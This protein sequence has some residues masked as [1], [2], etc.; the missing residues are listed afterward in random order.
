[1]IIPDV[2]VLV[3]AHQR[4]SRHFRQFSKLL[5]DV[6][7]GPSVV[8]IP[9][10]VVAGFARVV[11]NP[12]LNRSSQP[13]SHALIACRIL[14]EHHNTVR[15]S[16]SPRAWHIFED[17]STRANIRG[18]HLSDAYLAAVTIDAGAELLTADRGFKR[19]AGLRVT[20]VP[21]S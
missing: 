3:Y 8:G 16:P 2:N 17:L 9:D 10:I 21:T 20:V 6:L 15:V 14:I 1:M 5:I 13:L 12:R 7:D 19:F 11:T 4:M 18:T